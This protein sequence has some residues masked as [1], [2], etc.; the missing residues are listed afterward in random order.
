MGTGIPVAFPAGGTRPFRLAAQRRDPGGSREGTVHPGVILTPDQRLRVFVSSTLHELAEERKAVGEAV[1]AL[2]LSPVMFELGARPHPPRALYRSYLRQSHIFVGVYWQRYGWIAP[3]EAVSGLEDEYGLAAELPKLI[4][5]KEPAGER[6]ARLEVLLERIRTDDQASYRP[7]AT[8]AELRDLVVEDL[9]LLLSE[10]FAVSSPPTATPEPEQG[11]AAVRAP[12]P[13]P[14]TPLIGRE[15]EIAAVLG[16][17]RRSEVRLVTLTGPGGV[18]KSRLALESASRAAPDFEDGVVF[19]S[20]AQLSE[21][22]LLLPTLARTLGVREGGT[23]L[24]DRLARWLDGKNILLLLDNLEQL[25]E[26]APQLSE[27][28]AIAPGP[29]LLVTSRAALRLGPERIFEVPPLAVPDHSSPLQRIAEAEAVQLFVERARARRS[30]FALDRDNAAAVAEICRRLDGIPLALEL[31]AARTAVLSPQG[32]LQRLDRRFE[33]LGSGASDLP[34]RQKTLRST[35]DWSYRL[36]DDTERRLFAMLGV[37]VGGFTLE[38][39]GEVWSQ[40]ESGVF[41]PLA[42][43]LDNSLVRRLDSGD[44]VR[45][46]MFESLREFA[47]ECLASSPDAPAIHRRHALFCLR[48]AQASEANHR[49]G[50]QIA[51]LDRLEGEHD[52]LRAALAWTLSGGDLE[53]GVRLTVLLFHF[54]Y[55]RSHYQEGMGWLQQALDRWPKDDTGQELRPRLLAAAGTLADEMGRGVHAVA[56]FEERLE[57]ARSRGDLAGEA[58]ALN[59]LGAV[60]WGQGDFA[61]AQELIESSL[62]LRRS[63]GQRRLLTLALNNLGLVAL[64]QGKL[65][66]AQSYLDECL[67]LCREL[68]DTM[69][70]GTALCN[71][72]LVAVERDDPARAG[73]LFEEALLSFRALGDRDGLA[74]AFEGFAALASLQH[75]FET[76]ARLKG[77]AE[78]V[79]EAADSHLNDTDAEWLERR[80]KPAR[81]ALGD[82]AFT[83]ARDRGRTTTPADGVTIAL[84]LNAPRGRRHEDGV[85]NEG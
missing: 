16:L 47:V 10:R 69:G 4:Y 2:H 72:G 24:R 67:A 46:G 41:E 83:V 12:L 51:W 23:P 6:E 18:G 62:T 39:A 34:D 57:L 26:A 31:A 3:G 78:A 20:L 22:A 40:G 1:R 75:E 30:D 35:I 33:L 45:F 53:L 58:A 48:L 13:R 50:E 14:P 8:A 49:G 54:W 19:V 17:L 56:L 15:R 25:R 27:L 37:F 66:D 28:L 61:R 42:S 7:F 55:Y 68:N 21:S 84:A 81:I 52:N 73:R 65:E 63:L 70:I 77:V 80:L 59:S 32:L 44:E 76:A 9:A 43:L 11:D 74:H 29:K 5:V 36:L 79:R 60:S 71:L 64:A 38:A 85:A 82:R